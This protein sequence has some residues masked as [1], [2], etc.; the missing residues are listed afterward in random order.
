MARQYIQELGNFVEVRA[1][2]EPS[3]PGDPWIVFRGLFCIG[4]GVIVHGSEFET[5]ERE[6]KEAYAFLDEKNGTTGIQLDQN[7]QN[8]K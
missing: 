6:S 4:L 3:H 5:G 1:T 8:R 2:E 7:P